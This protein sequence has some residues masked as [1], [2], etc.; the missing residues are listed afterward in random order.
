MGVKEANIYLD[1]QYNT[2]Y[3]GQT[4]NGRIEYV[5]DKPKKV[6]GKCLSQVLFYQWSQHLWSDIA[7]DVRLILIEMCKH[8]SLFNEID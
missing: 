2:Y 3:A 4:V 8:C 7:D 1:N 6:R 5:F